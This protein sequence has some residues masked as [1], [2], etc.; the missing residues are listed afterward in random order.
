MNWNVASFSW[1]ISQV[2]MNTF[3]WL[4]KKTTNL[5]EFRFDAT[6]QNICP[7]TTVLFLCF[8]GTNNWGHALIRKKLSHSNGFTS[9]NGGKNNKDILISSWPFTQI[10]FYFF[11]RVISAVVDWISHFWAVYVVSICLLFHSG[12]EKRT[13]MEFWSFFLITL[14]CVVL[15][16]SFVKWVFTLNLNTWLFA[17][18]FFTKDHSFAI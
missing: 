15:V 4:D 12:N 9:A 17:S 1:I 5:F 10:P 14:D 11:L 8:A 2:K 7:G 16:R 13:L 18:I 6:K 3:E